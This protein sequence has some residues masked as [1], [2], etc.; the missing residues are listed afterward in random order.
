MSITELYVNWQLPFMSEVLKLPESLAERLDVKMRHFLAASRI[1]DYRRKY[2][3]YGNEHVFS[4]LSGDNHMPI[5]TLRFI[6][7]SALNRQLRRIVLECDRQYMDH[8]DL[9]SRTKSIASNLQKTEHGNWIADQ[10]ADM[11][12]L[13]DIAYECL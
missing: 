3:C 13:F 9:Y 4:F 2:R 10:E 7:V 1:F 5:M 11:L 8:F 6:K 12:A